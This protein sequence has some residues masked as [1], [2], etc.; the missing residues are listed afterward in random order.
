MKRAS[1]PRRECACL[2]TGL[3]GTYRGLCPGSCFTVDHNITVH[4]AHFV[5]HAATVPT[6][7]R[8]EPTADKKPELAAMPE[9]MPEP[10]IAQ[11]SEPDTPDQVLEHQNIILHQGSTGGI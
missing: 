7:R 5:P 9:P 1:M 3:K 11:D 4:T 8:P 6:D 2:E 10:Y